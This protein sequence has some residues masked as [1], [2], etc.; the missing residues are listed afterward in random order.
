MKNIILNNFFTSRI[1]SFY[2]HN[3]RIFYWRNKKL[4]PYN[5]FIIELLLKKTK[6]EKVNSIIKDFFNKYP[7][8]YSLLN[9]DNQNI[10]N[11]IYN[12]GLGNQRLKGLK[13]ASEFIHKNYNDI[14]PCNKEK[15]LKIPYVGMYTCNAIL[16]FAFNKR[17]D[18]LDVNSSRLIARFFSIR[19]DLDIRDN[20]ELVKKSRELLPLWK[21]KDYN[22]GLL[23][24]G[25][26]ICKPKPRCDICI[27]RKKCN[28]II[29]N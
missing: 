22:W 20:K 12:L 2:F 27:L 11:I 23:D 18:I 17:Y 3:R 10:Y 29:N 4:K 21:V 7:D 28:Y 13:K 9:G 14:I 24:F 25:A 1:I 26:L 8:N 19:N 5:I 15:L 6:A 16:C